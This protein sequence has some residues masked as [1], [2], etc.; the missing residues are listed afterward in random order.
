M[1]FKVGSAAHRK[2]I[3]HAH[4]ATFGQQ[5]IYQMAANKPSAA[6]DDI[7]HSSPQFLHS[8]EVISHIWGV[9]QPIMHKK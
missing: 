3:N 5:T 4:M 9:N 1:M 8:S 6:C 7:N 2:V